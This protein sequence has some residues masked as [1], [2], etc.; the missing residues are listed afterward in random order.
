MSYVPLDMFG[1]V[2]YGGVSR[3]NSVLDRLQWKYLLKMKNVHLSEAS[4]KTN[5]IQ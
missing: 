2:C 3:M 4:D 1:I 5:V